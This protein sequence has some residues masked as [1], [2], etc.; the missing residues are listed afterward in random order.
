MSAPVPPCS[1][2]HLVI[3]RPEAGADA[4]EVLLLREPAGWSLPRIES[5]EQRSADVTALNRAVRER[6]GIEV[7]VLRCLRDDPGEEDD[8]RRQVHDLDLHSRGWTPPAHGKWFGRGE[9]DATPLARP[10]QRAVL[11]GW[12]RERRARREP[13]D[14]RDWILPGWREQAIGWIES[15]LSRHGLGRLVE[16]EQVRVWEFS[17]VLR[18]ATAA[19]SGLYFKALPHAAA[20]EPLLTRYLAQLFPASMPAVIAV[21]PGHRWLLTRAAEGPALMDVAD[22]ARWEEAAESWARLGLDCGGRV[23]ELLALG[24]PARPLEWLEAE[25]PPLLDDTAAMQP[26]D[27]E[28]LTGAEVERLRRL[29]PEL[30]AMCRELDGFGLPLSLDHGDLW[31]VNVIAG[32]HRCVFIDWEDASVSHPFFSVFLLLASLDYTEAL[33][34]VPDARDRIRDA[35][36]APWRERTPVCGWPAG[37]L[38]RAFELSQPLAAVHYAVQFRRFALPRIETSR[39]VRAFAPLFLRALL[40]RIPLPSGERAG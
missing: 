21:E 14:G 27:A 20:G 25:I 4:P 36:L 40:R 2:H 32:D 33:A 30:Q 6:L 24:C 35:Y 11:D 38:E 10:E 7:T 16:V 19:G 31:G 12:F 29:A 39:E 28:A 3:G 13:V 15:E 18:L 26:A 1:E 23:G 17:Q 34:H 8:A 9:L 22:L 5:D 37:R